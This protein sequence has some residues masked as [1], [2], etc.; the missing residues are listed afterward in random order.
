MHFLLHAKIK[1]PRDV[2]NQEFFGAWQREASASRDLAAQGVPIF[3]VAGKYEVVL[4]IEVGSA[5]ELDEAIHAL[6][7]WQEGYQDM[8]RIEAT[9]LRPYTEWADHLD[10]LAAG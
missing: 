8:V 10:K 5:T 7:I 3:K 1:K 9:A 6:P 2:S 4:I